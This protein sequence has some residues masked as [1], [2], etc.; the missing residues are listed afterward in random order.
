M[1]VLG[2]PA[3]QE[4][5]TRDR[6]FIDAHQLGGLSD[7]APVGEVF[8]D[9]QDLVVREPGVEEGSSLELGE[10]G[11]AGPAIEEPVAALPEVVDDEEVVLAPPTIRR[12]IGVLATEAGEVVG[13][14]DSSWT[15][16][17]GEYSSWTASLAIGKIQFN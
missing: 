5:Q 13:G 12:A 7:A 8:Q 6:V 4:G 1:G 14:H 16:P 3:G 11:L 17:A 2:V 9:R 15:D 10:P